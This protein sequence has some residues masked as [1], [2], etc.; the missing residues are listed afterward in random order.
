MSCNHVLDVQLD[1][2]AQCGQRTNVAQTRL[3]F[4]IGFFGAKAVRET[5]VA[6]TRLGFAIGLFGTNAAR[7]QISRKTRLG[8]QF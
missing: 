1:S 4:A 7:E 2:S 8:L 5:D 3:D 6:W